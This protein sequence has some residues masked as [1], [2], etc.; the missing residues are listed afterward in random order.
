MWKGK[1]D[2][3]LINRLVESDASVWNEDRSA[4]GTADTGHEM[5]FI[6]GANPFFG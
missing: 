2:D 5:I 6:G 1:R 3:A 4:C